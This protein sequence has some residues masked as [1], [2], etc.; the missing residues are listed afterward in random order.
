MP[1][2]R[3]IVTKA[4][5]GRGKKIFSSNHEISLDVNPTNILGCWVINHSFSGEKINNEV[6]ISG[7]FDVNLWYSNQENTST[8]VVKDV[9]NYKEK[10]N[11]KS[12]DDKYDGDDEIIV[13]VVKQPVCVKAEIVDGVIKYVIEKEFAV[14]VVGDVMIRVGIN[15]DDVSLDDNDDNLEKEI[16]DSVNENFL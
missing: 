5:V 3:E 12:C 9:I 4:V 14:E 2:Y 16:N 7:S 15:E 1:S 8:D 11:I 10:I 13:R 6:F